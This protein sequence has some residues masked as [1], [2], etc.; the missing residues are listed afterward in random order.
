MSRHLSLLYHDVLADPGRLSG[1]TGASAAAYKI[2]LAKF[3]AHLRLLSDGVPGPVV[4]ATRSADFDRFPDTLRTLT[5]DDGGSS[6][7]EPIATLLTELG[8]VGHFFIPTA[9]LG[10]AGFIDRS[11]LRQIR[12]LGHAIG[13]HS[14]THPM[15]MSSLPWTRIVEEWTSSRDAL[16][17]ELGE[18]VTSASVPGGFYS[19]RVAAAAAEAGIEVLY[20]SE[21]TTRI[22]R[23][24]GCV[25]LGRYSVMDSTS[26]RV[27]MA[28]YQGRLLPRLRQSTT[29]TL[30]KGLKRLGGESWLRLREFHFTRK[31]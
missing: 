13:S 15:R 31:R 19:G 20:T 1:F 4:E 11:E 14:H 17:Q 23:S 3:K 28:L 26:G 8:W 24:H 7:R 27:V 10:N 30:K 25:V 12:G 9:F 16:E 18:T 6:A 29:W 21:P 22:Q 2:S 5:F